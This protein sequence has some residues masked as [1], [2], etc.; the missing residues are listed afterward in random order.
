VIALALWWNADVVIMDDRK[1]RKRCDRLG[2][3]R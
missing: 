3:K 2:L 1:A